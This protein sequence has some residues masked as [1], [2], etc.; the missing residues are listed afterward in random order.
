[1]LVDNLMRKGATKNQARDMIGNHYMDFRVSFISS[2][3][4][5]LRITSDEIDI[6]WDEIQE[7]ENV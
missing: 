4:V 7:Y 1:M 5:K 2:S 6:W 3:P